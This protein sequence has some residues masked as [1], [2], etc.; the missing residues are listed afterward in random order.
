MSNEEKNLIMNSTI[1]DINP[2]LR[3]AL[4]LFK[5]SIEK[6]D[7]DKIQNIDEEAYKLIKTRDAVEMMRDD[8]SMEWVQKDYQGKIKIPCQL[9][10]SIKSEDKYVIINRLNRNELK[11]GSSCIDKFPKMD[12][13]L[14]GI[15]VKEIAKLNKKSP[16]KLKKIVKFNELYSGGKRIFND[17][18]VKYNSFDI[19]FPKSYDDKL[20]DILKRG[21][22][23]YNSYIN[24]ITE[25]EELK[26]FKV[27]IDD[28]EYLYNNCEKYLKNEKNNKYICTKKVARLLEENNLKGILEYIQED[29]KI[30]K[31]VAKYVYHIDFISKFNNEIKNAF[32]KHNLVL[33]SI[34]QQLISFTW[35]YRQF[36]PI[37]LETSLKNF[38]YKFSDIFFNIDTFDKNTIY[39]ELN[40]TSNYKN[41]YEFTGI[42]EQLLKDTEYYFWFHE[43]LYKKQIIELHKKGINKYAILDIKYILN[44]FKELLYLDNITTKRIILNKLD[45][46]DNWIDKSDKEKYDIGNI[47][48][49][50][51]KTN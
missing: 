33:N 17:W 40:I 37:I 32:M 36:S 29:G 46:L 10:G 9:C 1:C 21:R 49:V 26:M 39:N 28:F 42:M 44:N 18:L 8:A 31:D 5:K 3:E 47:S 22:K 14:Y 50:W 19:V 38:T 34:N 48:D 51:S 45:K 23:I 4:S 16:E 43:G 27:C 25:I 13:K 30:K 35:K 24:G 41:I 7:L 6:R 11:V 12:N 20:S 2:K 15:S